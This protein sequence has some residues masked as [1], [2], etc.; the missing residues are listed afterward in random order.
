MRVRIIQSQ[1]G[2]VNRF[3]L[4]SLIPGDIYE[5]DGALAAQLIEM[6][7]AQPARS[8]DAPTTVPL[9]DVDVSSLAGG[10]HVEQRDTAH[11]RNRRRKR[12]R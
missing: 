6:R 3:P 1:S 5:L 9:E 12:R 10:V 7:I 2:V 11:D 4:S 8:T